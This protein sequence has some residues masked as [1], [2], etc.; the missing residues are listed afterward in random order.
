MQGFSGWM[1]FGM[2]LVPALGSATQA[3]PGDVTGTWDVA[4][5]FT[6]TGGP[7]DGRSTGMK[8]VFSL[9]QKGT[10]LTGT[11]V[12]YAEDGKTAQPALPIVEGRVAGNKITFRVKSDPDTSLAFALVLAD[13]HLRGTGTPS[14]PVAGGGKLSITIDATRRK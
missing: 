11:F 3:R 10:A 5:T 1:M 8:A 6:I 7:G 2:A 4:A 9:E 13:G 12:P 14:K